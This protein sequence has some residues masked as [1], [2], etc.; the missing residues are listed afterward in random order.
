M[1]RVGKR[2]EGGGRQHHH[3]Q[4]GKI[5]QLTLSAADA[6]M[7]MKVQTTRMGRG[8]DGTTMSCLANGRK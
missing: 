4:E 8:S 2:R 1:V 3:H 7:R 5:A 6:R